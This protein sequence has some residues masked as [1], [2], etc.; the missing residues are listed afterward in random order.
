M[1][2]GEKVCLGPMLQPDA[3]MIFN[4]L[5]TVSL[6]HLNGNYIPVSQRS[7]DEWFGGIGKDSSRVVFSIRKHG[8]LEFLGYIQLTEIHPVFRSAVIGIIIGDPAHRGQGYG[9]EALTLCTGFCWK[10]LNLQRLSLMIA[11]KNEP[12]M[13]AYKKAGFEQEGVLKRAIFANGVYMDAT[14][15]GLLRSD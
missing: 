4:W 9:Q 1:L 3:A 7:F 15:M 10:E 13:R 2:I 14:I 5:N 11:G 8:N 12:A 6:M